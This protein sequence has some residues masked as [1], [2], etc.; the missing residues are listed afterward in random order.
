MATM[1]RKRSLIPWTK[2]LE[3]CRATL[4]QE[5][6]APSDRWIEISSQIQILARKVSD[7]FSY[8]DI[9]NSDIKGESAILLATSAFLNE[10]QS[11]RSSAPSGLVDNC[12]ILLL[13]LLS[14][15]SANHF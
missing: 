4:G 13:Y 8:E 11:I 6:N 3:Q 5:M 12:N 15:I 10:L 14:G 1:L 2:Y 9:I 7:A